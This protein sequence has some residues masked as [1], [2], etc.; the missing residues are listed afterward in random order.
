MISERAE[1]LKPVT[2]DEL[3]ELDVRPTLRAGGEAFGQIMRTA[4]EV[5]AGYVL[6][7]RATFKPAPLFGVMRARGWKHWI[8]RGEGDDWIVWFYRKKDFHEDA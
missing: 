8:E 2:E 4:G 6:R 5:P 3:V 1:P 7:L